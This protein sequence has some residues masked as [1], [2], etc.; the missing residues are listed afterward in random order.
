MI[1]IRRTGDGFHSGLFN[2]PVAPAQRWRKKKGHP[3]EIG[4][5]RGGASTKIYAVVEAYG[6]PVRLMLSEGQRNDITCAIPI[7]EQ[8]D[9][10][11]S[12][13]LADRGYDSNHLI[14]YI[15]PKRRY[16]AADNHEKEEKMAFFE[17]KHLNA[18]ERSEKI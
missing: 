12:F 18:T 17:G 14:D 8:I 10:E 4:H 3:N 13:I 15:L 6:N 5:S 1:S 9:I 16:F 7:L 2:C 11:G